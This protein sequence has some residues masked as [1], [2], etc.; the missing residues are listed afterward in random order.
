MT[1]ATPLQHADI[2]QPEEW[3]TEDRRKR[4]QVCFADAKTSLAISGLLPSAIRGWI[5]QEVA[6]GFD[7]KIDER[8]QLSGSLLDE[9]QKHNSPTELGLNE[10]TL[11]E[12]LTVS[13]GVQRW[14]SMLWSEQVEALF[15]ANKE[16]YDQASFYLLRVANLPLAKELYH[17]LKSRETTFPELSMKYGEGK[18]ARAGGHFPLCLLKDVPYSLGPALRTMTP[19]HVE[20]PIALGKRFAILMLTEY[21]PAEYSPDLRRKLLKDRFNQWLIDMQKKVLEA[22]S[23]D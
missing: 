11:P 13:E 2:H 3:L 14:S 4:I 7:W 23:I 19:N 18:E 21:I 5:R 8:M 12:H 20:P 1:Q 9:W 6:A 17:R 16:D 15:L 22:L 10:Q